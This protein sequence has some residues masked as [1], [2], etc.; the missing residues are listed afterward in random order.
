M[1]HD[2]GV[3]ILESIDWQR[4]NA[5]NLA[6]WLQREGEWYKVNHCE[7]WNNF[8]EDTFDLRACND[9]GLSVWSIILDES[10]YGVTEASPVGFAAWGFG[11][12]RKNF[13][14][15]NFGTNDDSGYNF[16]TEERRILL[17]LKAFILHMSGSVHGEDVIGINESLER[18][19]GAGAITCIDNR[20]M[21]FS[22]L[23]YSTELSGL[24]I[25]LYNRD[26]LPRPVGI[27]LKVVKN[28]G[29]KS[30]GFGVNRANF[31]NGNFYDGELIGD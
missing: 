13:C 17:Q 24:A 1:S 5:T 30:W 29:I 21:S 9:F 7:F 27:G 15:G 26:L 16:T 28:A 8:L 31:N 25:E 18:I 6:A 12:N 11:E 10:T 19:F 14:N 20:D 22:Y 4:S 2:A 3:E 23:V